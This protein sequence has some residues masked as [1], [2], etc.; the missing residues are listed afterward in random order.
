[1]SSAEGPVAKWEQRLD[2]PAGYGT[3]TEPREPMITY[4]GMLRRPW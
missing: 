2:A 4:N 1:M 3:G